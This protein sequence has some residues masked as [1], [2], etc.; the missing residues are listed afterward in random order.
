[1]NREQ[2]R[3]SMG[4]LRYFLV[5]SQHD[6]W[7]IK[8]SFTSKAVVVSLSGSE[9][10]WREMVDR[11]CGA[12]TYI[13]ENSQA[14]ISIWFRHPQGLKFTNKTLLPSLFSKIFFGYF[15][16]SSV[17]KN[18]LGMQLYLVSNI[19]YLGYL[20]FFWCVLGLSTISF[21]YI[22]DYLYMKITIIMLLNIN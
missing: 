3:I 14:T 1:M 6:N 10:M 20:H 13:L 15:G 9:Q 17:S 7:C 12:D 22:Q 21:F 18:N 2:I 5:P 8:E 11:S 16:N 4:K 19:L